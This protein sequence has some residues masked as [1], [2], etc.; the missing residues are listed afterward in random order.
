MFRRNLDSVWRGAR[1]LGIALLG[2]TVVLV[3]VAMVVLPGPAL[4]VIP[5]GLGI[6]GIEFAWA[7]RLHREARVKAQQSWS[8]IVSQLGGAASPPG[9]PHLIESGHQD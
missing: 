6:L 3:G 1:K 5:V 9:A 7:R 4:I 8:R 2:A